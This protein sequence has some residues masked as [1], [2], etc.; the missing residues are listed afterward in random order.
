VGVKKLETSWFE[1]PLDSAQTRFANAGIAVFLL[2]L[3][4]L[5]WVGVVT[6]FRWLFL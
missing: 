4:G 1:D 2:L 3:L 6:V 5:V